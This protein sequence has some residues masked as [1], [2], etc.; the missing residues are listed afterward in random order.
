[1]R[2]H[3]AKLCG[4]LP[5]EEVLMSSQT[6]ATIMLMYEMGVEQHTPDKVEGSP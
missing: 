2:L 5:V 3:H 4:A 1:M 6:L